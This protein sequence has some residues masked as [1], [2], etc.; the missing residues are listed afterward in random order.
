MTDAAVEP[1]GLADVG[2]VTRRE[3]GAAAGRRGRRARGGRR[4]RR[5]RSRSAGLA[6]AVTALGPPRFV[7]ET[8]AAGIDHTYDGEF[9]YFVGGGVAVFDCDDDGRPD[10]Y[11]AGGERPGGPV[12]EREPGRRRAAVRARSP[13]R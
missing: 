4:H 8:A 12:P 2:P 7:E 13:T 3:S 9:T 6:S 5:R 10:L 11:L 1:G